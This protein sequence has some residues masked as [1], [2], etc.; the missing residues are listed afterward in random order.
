MEGRVVQ[1]IEATW[2]VSEDNLM[3]EGWPC[4]AS[5]NDEILSTYALGEYGRFESG[6]NLCR[7]RFLM[8]DY[9]PSSTYSLNFVDM[10]DRAGNWGAAR[11]TSEPG[12]EDPQRI[13]VRTA[14]PDTEP[15]ELDLNRMSIDAEP[16]ES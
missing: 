15:P 13:R 9:R 1:S 14:N 3:P 11:F 10:V 5:I 4:H 8:P 6:G 12:D 7:V 16:H 2:E